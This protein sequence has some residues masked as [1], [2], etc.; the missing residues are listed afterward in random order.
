MKLRDL[1]KAFVGSLL[2][3][4]QQKLLATICDSRAMTANKRIAVHLGNM[5]F[6]LSAALRQVYPICRRILGEDYF[7]QVAQAYIERYPS[8]H[9]DLN[10]Y[11]ER[12]PGFFAELL[13]TR[14]ELADFPYLPDLA[15]LE[16]HLHAAYYAAD[17]APFDFDAFAQATARQS[18]KEIRFLLPAALRLLTSAYPLFEIW[19]AN[20]EQSAAAEVGA[21]PTN[22][23]LCICRRNNKPTAEP[24]DP[25][26]FDLLQAI[27][28]GAT[29]EQLAEQFDTLDNDL[30]VLIKDGR[31]CGFTATD[32]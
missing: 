11:G 8:E 16:S 17:D 2:G 3:H 4:D 19:R 15:R 5:R 7:A 32:G 21:R 10:R 18:D 6:S 23:Y 9:S 24:I 14:D 31:I 20:K 12:L 22:E 26:H 29:L 13:A 27:D 25:S 28:K 1:Q 30:P